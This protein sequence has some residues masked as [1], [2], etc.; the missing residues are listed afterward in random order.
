LG[1]RLLQRGV[2]TVRT[3]IR[4]VCLTQQRRRELRAA[5]Q[6]PRSA[7]HVQTRGGANLRVEGFPHVQDR[8]GQRGR[9]RQVRPQLTQSQQL[10]QRVELRVRIQQALGHGVDRLPPPKRVV[11]LYALG[12]K[13]GADQLAKPTPYLVRHS[14][15]VERDEVGRTVRVPLDRAHPVATVTS[16]QF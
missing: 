1:V 15:R 10:G 12:N 5:Q 4:V 9:S 3:Q 16:R 7:H 6:R 8:V 11:N 14:E 13:L 2:H